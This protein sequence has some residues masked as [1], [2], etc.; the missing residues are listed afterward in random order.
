MA[1]RK[2]FFVCLRRPQDASDRRDDPF[3]EFGSFGCTRCHSTNLLHPRNAEKLEK[4]RLAFV[5]GGPSGSRL[6]FLTPPISVQMLTD[7]AN[8]QVCVVRWNPKEMPFIYSQAPI[9]VSNSEKTD[10]CKV[11]DYVQSTNRTTDEGRFSSRFRARTKPIPS[12]L[13][14]EV[15][16]VYERK[17]K[18]AQSSAIAS[19]YWQSL[20]NIPLAKD[21]NRKDSYQKHI[22]KL[23]GYVH[24]AGNVCH[25]EVSPRAVCDASRCN[26]SR[27]KA[28]KKRK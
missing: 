18:D 23:P 16:E 9:L 4:A 8:C 10:F 24:N 27:K 1:E 26:Q 3:Y 13:A 14:N 5:Q 17:R 15:I 2:V 20:P 7:T 12:E 19:N 25:G 11:R 28:T 22:S 21:E 6:V